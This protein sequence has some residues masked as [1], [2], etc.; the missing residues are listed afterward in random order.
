MTHSVIV[1]FRY[2]TY[3]YNNSV[4]V[5]LTTSLATICHNM[6]I[7]QLDHLFLS[8]LSFCLLTGEFNSCT[9]NVITDKERFNSVFLLFVC[10]MLYIF[11]VPHFLYH[12]LL[13]LVYSLKNIKLFFSFSFVYILQLL[14]MCDY[15]GDFT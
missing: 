4:Y 13:C 5:M 2:S 1:S 7:L 10:Y 8:I 11:F 9:F 3:W 12:F 14:H 6:K 15:N